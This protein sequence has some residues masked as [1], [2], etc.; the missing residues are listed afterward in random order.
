MGSGKTMQ[1]INV[2]VQNKVAY[3]PDN[4]AIVC[5]NNDYVIQFEF[6]AEW[7]PYTIKTARFIYNGSYADVVFE[8]NAVQVPVISN[9]TIVAV[10]VFAGS[11]HTTTSC[12]IPC[13]KSIVC[14]NGPVADPPMDVYAQII[15]M[16]EDIPK[17]DDYVGRKNIGKN[18][19]IF[20]D[21]KNNV[22]G[23]RGY[24]WSDIDFSGE[25]PVITFSRTQAISDGEPFEVEYVVGDVIS[26]VNNNH[27]T[28]CSTIIDIQNN[29]VTVD[30]LPFENIVEPPAI[31]PDDYSVFVLEKPF[32]GIIELGHFAHAEG[33]GTAA[34][35]RGGHTEGRDT[36]VIGQY[37]HAQN[38][39]TIAD[40]CAFA[41]GNKS[42]ALGHISFAFGAAARALV[43]AAIAIGMGVIAAGHGQTAMGRF[44]IP[45]PENIYAYILGNGTEQTRSNAHTVDWKGNGWFSGILKIGG[46]GQNDPEA[47]TVA[48]MEDISREAQNVLKSIF[49]T[50]TTT[51]LV[52]G[53][54][55]DISINLLYD[56]GVDSFDLS[57]K[58]TLLD[59][60]TPIKD[61]MRIA[62][63]ILNAEDTEVVFY[64]S[65][66]IVYRCSITHT[67]PN[68]GMLFAI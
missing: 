60:R 17:F 47:K 14:E 52:S 58:G 19:E 44:N 11:L 49:G 18:S 42:W 61:K 25:H 46:T 26:I 10:G 55:A 13:I 66:K 62:A 37:G 41:G 28:N 33:E 54:T 38:R 6:D 15:K 3:S 34:Y 23:I 29:R 20:N 53:I 48:T 45:D 7:K 27:H 31:T 63:Q 59:A 39:E 1:V 35:E 36:K 21:Y 56:I 68:C 9:C 64:S 2:V 57:V 50:F 4:V 22:A 24:Y 12:I 32:T 51:P 16:L 5:G 67:V 8:G 65:D 43:N 30:T 40:Y